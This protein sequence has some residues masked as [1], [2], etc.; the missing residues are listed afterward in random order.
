MPTEPDY[1]E[2]RECVIDQSYLVSEEFFTEVPHRLIRTFATYIHQSA[3]GCAEAE[4][5]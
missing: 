2:W 4:L 3:K 1:V 5:C